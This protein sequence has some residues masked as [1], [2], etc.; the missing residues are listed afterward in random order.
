MLKNYVTTINK[1][2]TK[3]SI[4]FIDLFLFLTRKPLQKDGN[5]VCYRKKRRMIFMKFGI[6]IET[7]DPEKA[8]NGFRFANASLKKGHEVKVF[9]MGEAVECESIDEEPYHV[10]NEM[11]KFIESEGELLACGTCLISRQLDETTSCP[12][13]TMMDCVAMV[14]W[15]DRMIT[16]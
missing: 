15:S 13:S 12:I 2:T 4:H 16:F 5:V 8:W 3:R 1:L 6:L 7:K 14:E 10:S 11:T 9:L